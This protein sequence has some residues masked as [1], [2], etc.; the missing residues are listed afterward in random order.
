MFN[1]YYNPKLWTQEA[2]FDRS[3]NIF[4]DWL[5]DAGLLGLIAYLYLF[6]VVLY[7]VWRQ[8]GP[9]KLGE[10]SL[11]TGMLA[12]YLFHNLFVF[13]NL[14]SYLYL[15]II[16]GY[17][18]Y[19]SVT[20]P[21]PASVPARRSNRL[22]NHW[23]VT[24]WRLSTM[25]MVGAL[26][27]IGVI[28]IVNLKPLLANRALLGALSTG[29]VGEKTNYFRQALAYKTFGSSEIA[30]QGTILAINVWG[31]NEQLSL[32]S[33]KQ[34][35]NLFVT[36]LG[37]QAKTAPNEAR[38]RY[39]SGVLLGQ[40]GRLDA[41]V[42]QL[43]LANDL[44]PRK[45]Q[46]VIAL[47]EAYLAV[48]KPGLALPLVQAAYL[49]D[50]THADSRLLY[51]NLAVRTKQYHFLPPLWAEQTVAYPDDPRNWFSWAAAEFKVGNKERAIEILNKISDRFSSSTEIVTETR[52]L[53]REIQ[54]GRDPL[55]EG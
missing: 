17:V 39:F 32:E 5:I 30:E 14:V 50:K 15:V 53:I 31:N 28:Y 10:K 16:L 7:Y 43:S 29:A 24:N 45:Q 27:L 6:M 46:I 40:A 18:H 21:A 51:I 8:S 47:A 25:A 9:F 36:E 42:T 55:V 35:T 52:R 48:D 11:I 19:R 54:A 33:K 34:L 12:A 37:R 20:A 44:T 1:Q 41:A 23:L 49:A 26:V 38:S 13:D 4:L 22:D 3:H 2:W